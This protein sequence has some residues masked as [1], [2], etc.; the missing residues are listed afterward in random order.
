ME[1]AKDFTAENRFSSWVSDLS[2][3]CLAK[4]D[5]IMGICSSDDDA[6]LLQYRIADFKLW[7]DGVGALAKPGL[8]LDKRFQH[9]PHDLELIKAVL[10]MLANFLEDVVFEITNHGSN[11]TLN[12][13]D[14]S[15]KNLAM[16][17]MAIRRTG[18]ASRRRRADES[19][20]PIDYQDL[21]QHLECIVLLRPSADQPRFEELNASE[22]DESLASS[23]TNEP[24]SNE[25]IVSIL[26][27]LAASRM[28]NLASSKLSKVQ[29]RLIEANLRRRLRFSLAQK[30]SQYAKMEQEVQ[31]N[32]APEEEQLVD[33][34]VETQDPTV[35]LTLRSK[36]KDKERGS[37]N[38]GELSV[39]ST[40]TQSMKFSLS[41]KNTHKIAPS[42][43][44][45]IGAEG[46]F[47]KPPKEA[48]SRLVTRCPCCYQSLP[49][50]VTTD[51]NAWRQHLIKDLCPYTCIAQHCPAPHLTFVTRK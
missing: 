2:K 31:A 11:K 51:P 46:E 3:I 15:I 43:I 40:A 4:F 38:I 27:K 12:N 20:D 48:P 35:K 47:P 30:R 44:S 41:G 42:Q 45:S 24:H 23:L 8:S 13:V 21:R 28:S 1:P 9:R 33:T 50:E 26:D 18:K 29:T 36:S 7:A 37:Q 6:E 5:Q 14:S 25:E 10:I 17:G 16:I 39:P 49:V 34:R 32:E 22:P 19:F